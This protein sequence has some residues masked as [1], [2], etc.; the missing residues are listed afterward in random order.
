MSCICC[1]TPCV[2]PISYLQIRSKKKMLPWNRREWTQVSSPEASWYR[3]WLLVCP[4]M[5]ALTEEPA[6]QLTLQEGADVL[7]WLNTSVS[8]LWSCT[9]DTRTKCGS[10]FF[11]CCSF[12]DQLLLREISPFSLVIVCHAVPTERMEEALSSL[13]CDFELLSTEHEI[14]SQSL[15]I[16][17][18]GDEVYI[19]LSEH[20]CDEIGGCLSTP[21]RM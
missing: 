10:L 3:H 6:A 20:S 9:V 5:Y 21:R 4:Q 13:P 2:Q 16:A 8:S 15:V 14:K 11:C 7:A 12:M 17:S 18:L 1:V 19:R